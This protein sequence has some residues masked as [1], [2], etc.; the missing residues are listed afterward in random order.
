MG[1]DRQHDE[2]SRA[3]GQFISCPTMVLWSL[4]DDLVQLYGDVLDVWRPW[5]ME[6]CGRGIDCGHH[7]AEETPEELA[8]DM[9]AFSRTISRSLASTPYLPQ[10]L[11]NSPWPFA[12]R[13][14]ISA[15]KA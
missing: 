8:T 1:I 5:T 4:K 7:T 3:A 11:A 12:A 14:R 10:T 13:D 15:W 2:E 6:L 9:L